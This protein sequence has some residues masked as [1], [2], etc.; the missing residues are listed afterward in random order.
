[1]HDLR[2]TKPAIEKPVRVL[3]FVCSALLVLHLGGC[4]SSETGTSGGSIAGEAPTALS[5][6]QDP[7][8]GG[9]GS[10]LL[11]AVDEAELRKAVERYR[12]S[13]QRSESRYEFAGVDLNGDGRPEAVALFSG[14]DWCVQTGCSLVVFQLEETGY[15]PVTHVTRALPPVLVGP[16]A[17]FGWKDLIVNTGGGAAPVRAVQL[18]FTG[19][20]YPGNALLQPDALADLQAR[21]QSVIA[22]GTGITAFSP[23]VGQS[24][25]Q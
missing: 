22:L 13:K 18:R 21:S 3:G 10:A 6:R 19:Q 17:N 14:N 4:G 8:A 25:T 15:R 16:D 12:I 2:P 11:A 7:S 1:M 24:Q 5:P 20:G 23:S 9:G